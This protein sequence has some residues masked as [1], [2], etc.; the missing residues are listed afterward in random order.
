MNAQA[1]ASAITIHFEA[2]RHLTTL[3]SLG[4]SRDA[5]SIFRFAGIMTF[6]FGLLA[7]RFREGRAAYSICDALISL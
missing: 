2:A 4:E 7:D 3:L 5:L 6:R 1:A